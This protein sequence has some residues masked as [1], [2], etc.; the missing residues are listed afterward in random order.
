MFEQEAANFRRTWERLKNDADALDGPA[1]K[2]I[3]F[4]VRRLCKE[5]LLKELANRS[6]I[7]GSGVPTAVVPFY[8]LCVETQK[9]QERTSSHEDGYDRNSTSQITSHYCAY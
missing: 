6:L 8:T 7:P 1:K 4:Q 2:A 3:E 5:F 9:A